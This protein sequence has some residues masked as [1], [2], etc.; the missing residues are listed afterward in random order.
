MIAVANLYHSAEM[1]RLKSG[2]HVVL[3]TRCQCAVSTV[4][5]VSAGEVHGYKRIF[6]AGCVGTSAWNEKLRDC[7]ILFIF[8]HPTRFPRMM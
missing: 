8:F 6:I 2:W 7:I 3:R 5:G 4:R 1:T